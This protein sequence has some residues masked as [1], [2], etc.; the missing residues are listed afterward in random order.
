MLAIFKRE[1]LS[2]FMTPVGYLVIGFF[3]ILN[4]LFLWVFKGTFNIFEYGFAD[5]GNF[6]LLTPWVFL[7]LTLAGCK[8]NSAPAHYTIHHASDLSGY[9]RNQDHLLDRSHSL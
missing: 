9:L 7:F 5:L 6:F 4:G 3:L 8:K 1:V 2:F